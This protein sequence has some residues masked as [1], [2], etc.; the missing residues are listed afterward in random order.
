MFSPLPLVMS[1][2]EDAV[3]LLDDIGLQPPPPD[4][5][6]MGSRLRRVYAQARATSYDELSSSELRKLPYAY[7][8]DDEPTLAMTDPELVRL[9]WTIHLSDAVQSSPRRAKR[10]LSPLFF[11]Y[12]EHFLH[13]DLMFTQFADGI[14][15]ALRSAQGAFADKLR[16]LHRTH[17]LFSPEDAPSQLSHYFFLDQAK[18]IDQLLQDILFWP[19]FVSSGLGNST[20]RW[21]LSLSGERLREAQTVL[22]LIDWSRR[23]PAPVVKTGLRVAFAE[24]LLRPWVGQRPSDFLKNTLVDFFLKEYGD[25]R[26]EGPRHYQW[27]GVSQ[28]AMGVLLNWLTGDTLRGFMKLLQRTADEIWHY[29]Q[30]FW[31]AYYE[32]GYI[33]EAWMA[34]GDNAF[35]EAKRLSM[36]EKGMGSGR[37]EGGAASNQSVLLLKIGGMVF[38]EWSHNGSLRAYREGSGEAPPFYKKTYDGNDLRQATS[39]DFHDGMNMNPELRHMNSQG[40]TWQRKARDFIRRNTGVYLGDREI[41]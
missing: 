11:V 29:R 41:L 28:Q 15:K 8:V 16:E 1:K 40:G 30:K 38:T 4:M 3:R 37:L 21:G 23:C 9:Y 22:R 24:G 19:G 27:D 39:M 20:F 13:K 6:D 33:D 18:T 5:M 17:R 34:L 26:F 32:K 10:W 31:M 35:W 7:W 2:L 25:P 12:S 36:D 14:V